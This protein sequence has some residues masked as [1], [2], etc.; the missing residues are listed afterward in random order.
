MSEGLDSPQSVAFNDPAVSTDEN[1]TEDSKV[2][3]TKSSKMT[4]VVLIVVAV[5]VVIALVGVLILQL[6]NKGGNSGGP[7]NGAISER[8]DPN[9]EQGGSG[10]VN[11]NLNATIV[12]DIMPI[13]E[14]ERITEGKIFFK[15]ENNKLSEAEIKVSFINENGENGTLSEVMPLTE[16]FGSDEGEEIQDNEL[17]SSDGT[18]K[19][20]ADVLAEKLTNYLSEVDSGNT[21]SCKVTEE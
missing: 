21:Y 11:S 8:T 18:L 1:Q 19:V 2:K 6:M 5:M 7:A 20:G 9:K 16:I 13:E 14:D 12:C 3:K 15:I 17:V 4:L 10:N